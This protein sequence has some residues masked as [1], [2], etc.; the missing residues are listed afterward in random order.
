MKSLLFERPLTIKEVDFLEKYYKNN[1][2]E[3][4]YLAGLKN[5]LFINV[6]LYQIRNKARSL[7]LKKSQ[8]TLK[9]IQKYNKDKTKKK[10]EYTKS[11]YEFRRKHNCNEL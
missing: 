9:K 1:A 11:L 4:I 5:S 3:K 7:G 6:S 10:W 8:E 2:T